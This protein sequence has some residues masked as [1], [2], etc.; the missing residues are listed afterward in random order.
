MS[1]VVVAASAADAQAVEAVKNHHAHL[2]GALAAHVESLVEAAARNDLPAAG[3]A[4][5]SLVRWCDAELIPH[6][7]AEEQAMYPPA[8]E[9]PRAAL[10]VDAMMAEHR[11]LAVLVERLLDRAFQPTRTG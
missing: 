3:A 11:D 6:A 8:H 1:T 4:A 2:A 9:D 7:L 10:L 5:G